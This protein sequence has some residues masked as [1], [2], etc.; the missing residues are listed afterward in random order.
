L[1]GRPGSGLLR[2]KG[3]QRK[4]DEKIMVGIS[5]AFVCLAP[6]VAQLSVP[7]QD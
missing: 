4:R 2:P 5:L 6:A 3:S 1:S 7:N